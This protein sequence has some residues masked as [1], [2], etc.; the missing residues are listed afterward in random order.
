[1]AVRTW[2][3]LR[4]IFY[5]ILWVKVKSCSLNQWYVCLIYAQIPSLPQACHQ[6]DPDFV[7]NHPLLESFLE[8]SR[9]NNSWK[10]IYRWMF[11]RKLGISI[12]KSQ[13]PIIVEKKSSQSLVNGLSDLQVKW[14]CLTCWFQHLQIS[15][16][17]DVGSAAWKLS[18]TK[19][20]PTPWPWSTWV[21]SLSG[22]LL[23]PWSS[24]AV[25]WS[26]CTAR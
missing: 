18:Q 6:F 1:M 3:A 16:S 17:G 24:W 19:L 21:M 4:R 9:R 22:W 10:S 2:V 26:C 14:F 11:L 25:N 5:P 13:M 20:C 12:P 23:H 15:H 8:I 7:I